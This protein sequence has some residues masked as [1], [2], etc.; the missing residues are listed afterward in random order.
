MAL[1]NLREL[2]DKGVQVIWPFIKPEAKYVIQRN[3]GTI[4]TD[5]LIE[6]GRDVFVNIEFIKMTIADS[7]TKLS[8][9]TEQA[10]RLLNIILD[11]EN[12]TT[13][14]VFTQYLI[15]NPPCTL[16]PTHPNSYEL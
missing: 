1:Y 4:I 12:R 6:E 13:D 2:R 16:I 5:E 11:V 8:I 7:I 15:E 3:H 14:S 10:T 9:T